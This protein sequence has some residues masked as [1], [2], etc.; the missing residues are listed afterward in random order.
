[1]E[2]INC[3]SLQNH[4]MSTSNN[5]VKP[6]VGMGVTEVCW[7]DRHPYTIIKVESERE[8]VVQADKAI[9]Q[10]KNGMSECQDYRFETDTRGNVSVLVLK[11]SKKSPSG[12]WVRKGDSINGT[13]YLLGERR[14][15]HD[16]SF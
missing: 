6:E 7:T 4:L 3:G 5:P 13:R 8:I 1:M 12:K 2:N 11:K 9:R 10:D 14:E 16:Y 15:Y